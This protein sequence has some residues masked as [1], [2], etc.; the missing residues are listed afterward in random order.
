MSGGRRFGVT[1]D[2]NNPG[3]FQ[4]DVDKELSKVG[5][6]LGSV[7]GRTTALEGGKLDASAVSAFMLTLLDEASAAA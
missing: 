1:G 5:R 6:E 7:E 4:E 2:V 3:R